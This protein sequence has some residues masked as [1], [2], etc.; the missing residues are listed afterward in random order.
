MHAAILPPSGPPD[1][2]TLAQ[3]ANAK[4][5]RAAQDFEAMAIGQ[6][7]APMFDTVDVAHGSFGGGDGEAAWRPMLTEAMA[8]QMTARG[9]I[10]IAVPVFHQMLAMQ[11]TTTEPAR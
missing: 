5:W 8:K 4:A 11:E 1:A 6:L 7:L 3:P 10:G 2:A 9:G